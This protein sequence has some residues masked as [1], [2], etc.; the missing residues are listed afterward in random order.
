MEADF[1]K[2]IGENNPSRLFIGGL[3]GK[4]GL[5]TIHAIQTIENLDL[6]KGGL[7]LCNMP[8]SP[9][10]STLD[11]IYYLSM[12]G[13]NVIALIKEYKPEIYLE[14]HCYRQNKKSKLTGPERME[15]SGVPGLVE[16][17]ESVLIGSTS[18]LIRSVFFKLYDFPFILEMP[19][20]PPSESLEVCHKIMKIAAKSSNRL[21]IMEKIG[22]IYPH[23]VERLKDYFDE[24]S[25]NFWPAFQELKKKTQKIDLN[26]Y[27][28]LDE[29]IREV[30]AEG[31][32]DLNQVQIK[33]LSQA[34]VIFREYG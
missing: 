10:L 20:N 32:Y 21:E 6:K 4:E 3:H 2:I 15:I 28:E 34:Y 29:L 17:E 31:N 19:C 9:Y 22:E 26:S 8:A 30:V 27:D 16:L 33:Q 5:S 23:Q 7:I 13:K 24:F 18:P 12:A 1:F 25:H 11:P 14:L